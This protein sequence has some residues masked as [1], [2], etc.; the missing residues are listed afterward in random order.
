M[1][2]VM[3]EGTW[4]VISWTLVAFAGVFLVLAGLSLIIWSDLLVNIFVIILGLLAIFLGLGLLA[5]GHL[6]GRAGFPSIFLLFFGLASILTGLSVFLWRDLV[7]DLIIY[8]GAGIA[9]LTGLLL[10]FLGSILS[11][12][13]WGRR[14]I[15]LGGSGLL[16]TGIALILF[17]NL[18]ARV[19]VTAG[20]VMTALAGCLAILFA[21][22][23]RQETGNPL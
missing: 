7:F 23:L 15:L 21:L 10:L 17:P 6:M 2:E 19:L 13:G 11:I 5:G 20:G 3:A 12:R 9:M 18:A 8:A 1:P 16:I 22:T 14:M 4:M